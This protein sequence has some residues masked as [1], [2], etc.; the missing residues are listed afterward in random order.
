MIKI[1]R[2]FLV[3]LVSAV[4][5]FCSSI[6]IYHTS[7]TH[8]YYYPHLI[9][10]KEIGGFAALSSLIAEDKNPRLLLDSGDYSSGTFEAAESKGLLSVQFMNMAGYNG[11]A[12]GNHEGD[13]GEKAM[14]D[15]IAAA[16]FD[17]LAANIFDERTGTYPEKIKP[18]AVYKVKDKKI[19]VIGI[20]KNPLPAS[21]RIKTIGL[22]KALKKALA[23]IKETKPDAT[24]LLI[25]ES[26]TDGL[27]K[28]IKNFLNDA[29]NSGAIDLVL[30]GHFHKIIQ[31]EK[32]DGTVFVESGGELKGASKIILNFSDKTGLLE[33]I[34]SEFIVL[35]NL[36]I[37]E[38]SEIK[39]F[40]D[41]NYRKDADYVLSYAK[42]RIEKDRY[43]Q[44]GSV[45][46]PLGNLFAD[47]IKKGTGAD[48]ALHNTG[49]LRADMPKGPITKRTVFGISPFSNKIIV[50]EVDGGFIKKFLLKSLKQ[51]GCS[52]QFSGLSVKYRYKN[53][54]PEIIQILVNGKPIENK[55]LY[56][57]AL[58]DYIAA[59]NSKGY[60]F[61]NVLNKKYFGDVS[62]SQLFE[63]YIKSNPQG[64]YGAKTGRI[65][66]EK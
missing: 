35:N 40:A 5:V 11:A 32:I 29:A 8:G 24:I 63:N 2:I 47:A 12:I 45:D 14:L 28:K 57:L 30:G 55:K 15:N 64:I 26:F 13:F 46:S 31:N 44:D 6:N 37:K 25:H 20:A 60:M 42:E 56:S 54:R 58:N 53:N 19:A 3:F 39:I 18:F 4:N 16:K 1:I 52:F 49:G 22:A 23:D 36:K 21:K 34:N 62:A 9:D 41:S 7:D 51:N 65:I 43:F 38:N 10:G 50:A 48:I 17:V 66:K 27:P 59:G 61:K 33:N